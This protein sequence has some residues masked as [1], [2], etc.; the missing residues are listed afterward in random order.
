MNYLSQ[1]RGTIE[2]KF[3]NNDFFLQ[4][5]YDL[6][7]SMTENTICNGDSAKE[8]RKFI[9][10]ICKGNF[11]FDNVDVKH[12][13]GLAILCMSW[14]ATEKEVLEMVR[15]S[16]YDK[17]NL[18]EIVAVIFTYQKKW[19]SLET[20]FSFL[21]ENFTQENLWKIAFA[22]GAGGN[23]NCIRDLREKDPYLLNHVWEGMDQYGASYHREA[24]RKM[25]VPYQ[26]SDTSPQNNDAKENKLLVIIFFLI[27]LLFLK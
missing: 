6:R 20:I 11:S 15:K 21:R 5:Y 12:Y 18:I 16:P 17:K 2:D 1:L 4:Q 7:S 13:H 26:H 19:T 27:C 14:F 9:H 3:P 22:A 8:G 10:R 25:C 24:L 23:F